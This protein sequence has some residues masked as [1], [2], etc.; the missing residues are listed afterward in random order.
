[1]W[2]FLQMEGTL[3][4]GATGMT[5]ISGNTLVVQAGGSYTQPFKIGDKLD[6]THVLAG[7][8]IA[9]DLTN[10][11]QFV[12]VVGPEH[13]GAG[14]G[15]TTLEVA[16]PGGKATINLVGAGKL[17]LKDLVKSESLILPHK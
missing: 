5:G 12:K 3:A 11:N 7:A 16:G 13:Q 9:H 2:K 14:T 8:P 10:L 6:L 4:G 15:R 1:V 17:D